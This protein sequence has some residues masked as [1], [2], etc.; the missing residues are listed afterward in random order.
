MVSRQREFE[1]RLP[2]G[3]TDEHGQIHQCAFIRKM[4]G[5][6]EA[7]LYDSTLS[8][9]RLV[10]ELI[11]N[12]LVRLGSI[13]DVSIELVSQLYTADRN[14]LLLEL[15]R[16]TLGDHLLTSYPCPRCGA[17]IEV[18]EDLNQVEV[19]RLEEG[20]QLEDIELI[21]EDGYTDRAQTTHS[22][23]TLSLPRGIDEE[24]VSPMVDKD[25][26]KA[27]DALLLRCIKRFGE[28]PQ[29][30]LEAYGVKILRDLT[31][32]DR[33]RIHT[34]LSRQA[35]GVNFERSLQ[36][37]PCGTRFEGVMDVSNFFV[38]G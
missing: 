33:Q 36:C 29:A 14:Y 24:F 26:L 35:P 12:C 18:V 13:E 31:M 20:E 21:L 4:C 16:I 37:G 15:R 2:I 19:R 23:I 28:L 27:Q 32:A 22:A 34:A 30:E 5:H 38:A 8:A 11:H 1:V 3:Y 17:G 9:G 7:L 6:E 25:P 10:T